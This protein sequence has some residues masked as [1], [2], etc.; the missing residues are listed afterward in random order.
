[1]VS[2]IDRFGFLKGPNNVQTRQGKFLFNEI[3]NIIAPGAV[4]G[5]SD[6]DDDDD[7]AKLKNCTCGKLINR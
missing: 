1:M 5:G 2:I 6:D 3:F 4:G 7:D